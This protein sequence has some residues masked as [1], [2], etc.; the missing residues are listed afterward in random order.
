VPEAIAEAFTE[1]DA[2][3]PW[4]EAKLQM[5]EA[6][7]QKTDQALGRH[8][9]AFEN[10][11][12]NEHDCATRINELSRK[13]RGLL[14]RREELAFDGADI[15]QALSD[16]QLRALQAHVGGVIEHGDP[17]AKKVLIQT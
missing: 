15:P 14:A 10:G 13:L 4:R 11:S 5:I 2:E 6:K 1:L 3:R 16:D 7:Q 8:F 12:L 9:T 17:P